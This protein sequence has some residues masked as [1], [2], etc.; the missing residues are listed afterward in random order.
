VRRQRR[1]A[2]ENFMFIY[3]LVICCFVFVVSIYEQYQSI[4]VLDCSKV[5]YG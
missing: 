3:W 4:W 1:A 5:L 2:C